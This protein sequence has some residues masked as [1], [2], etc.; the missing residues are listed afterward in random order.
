MFVK[1]PVQ[2]SAFT[3]EKTNIRQQDVDNAKNESELVDSWLDFFKDSV[4]VA[5]N[6]QFDIGFINAVFKTI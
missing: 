4:L 2:I 1:P 3:T 6:A 5:H